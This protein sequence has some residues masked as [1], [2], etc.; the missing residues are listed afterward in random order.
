MRKTR[1][2]SQK[3]L[4]DVNTVLVQK[5][6]APITMKQASSIFNTRT[7][8]AFE[9]IMGWA[10]STLS[11]ILRDRRISRRVSLRLRDTTAIV[12]RAA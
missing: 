5:G 12:Q 10:H 11:G 7:D 8:T 3:Q 9:F 1:P 4:D 6:L 2:L